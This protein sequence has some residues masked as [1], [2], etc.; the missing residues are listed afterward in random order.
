MA[1]AVTWIRLLPTVWGDP[2][3]RRERHA[4]LR[5]AGYQRNQSLKTGESGLFGHSWAAACSS[6]VASA[7]LDSQIMS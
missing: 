5:R 1:R 7:P 4:S 2:A 6:G 3:E